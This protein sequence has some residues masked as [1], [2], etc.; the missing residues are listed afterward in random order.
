MKWLTAAI[1]N[2]LPQSAE[3][4]A[5]QREIQD[6]QGRRSLRRY[7][8]LLMNSNLRLTPLPNGPLGDSGPLMKLWHEG[9][10]G[11]GNVPVSQEIVATSPRSNDDVIDFLWPD[12]EYEWE[13]RTEDIVKWIRFQFTEEIAE[14]FTTRVDG[15]EDQLG[16]ALHHLNRHTAHMGDHEINKFD[17]L[18]VAVD[19]LLDHSQVDQRHTDQALIS[20]VTIGQYGIAYLCNWLWRG[21]Q[22]QARLAETNDNAIYTAHHL[23]R[24]ST[25]GENGTS[26]PLRKSK[27]ADRW[28]KIIDAG[29]EAGTVRHS[30][31]CADLLAEFY[32]KAHD[33]RSGYPQIIELLQS[34][35]NPTQADQVSDDLTKTIREIV[36]KTSP[37]L[38]ALRI[39][40]PGARGITELPGPSWT[41][42]AIRVV[43]VTERGRPVRRGA[44]RTLRLFG[45]DVPYKMYRLPGSKDVT[46]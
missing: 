4:Y 41:Q 28:G 5:D 11:T 31:H 3:A 20:R 36:G 35:L 17:E 40:K 12:I 44:F 33:Q 45:S 46:K 9:R 15:W 10:S 38:L 1:D 43:M 18:R 39:G 25:L 23:R 22:Y 26:D 7:V 32:E 24:I 8:D 29:V 13:N 19:S 21:F 30:L 2:T 37:E 42:P 34:D 16:E 27:W 6:R 14:G